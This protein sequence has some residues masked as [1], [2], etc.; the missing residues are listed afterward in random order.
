MQTKDLTQENL[1]LAVEKWCKSAN[2][3]KIFGDL[4]FGLVLVVLLGGGWWC[5]RS[6]K[7]TRHIFYN[8]VSA[9][10][11]KI[12]DVVQGNIKKHLGGCFENNIIYLDN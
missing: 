8:E 11:C 12:V 10:N 4:L 3:W 1:D 9:H 5:V 6:Y 2:R 7:D